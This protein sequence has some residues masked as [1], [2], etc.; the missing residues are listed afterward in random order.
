MRKLVLLA[1]IFILTSIL[2]LGN[3]SASAAP[4]YTFPIS[5]CVTKYVNSHR[6]Y[7]A[8]DILAKKGC[9]FVAPISGVIDS[10]ATKDIWSGKTN[11]GQ[12]RGGLSISMI[13]DDGVRYYGSHL[14]KIEEGIAPGVLVTSGQKLGE[15]GASGSAK[16]TAPHV[17]FG[18]SYPTTPN[19]WQI[20]RGVTY[21]WKF[22]DAWKVGKDLS[23]A[24]V[25]AAAK[26]KAI[27]K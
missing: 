25:A 21:P 19:D 23:P 17:H 27:K 14:S 18:I 4:I 15:V 22:L 5:D 26:A 8:T 20:R 16:G 12:D 9:A 3:T 24:K 7:P 6:V 1:P 10:V 2:L 11:L 13:G